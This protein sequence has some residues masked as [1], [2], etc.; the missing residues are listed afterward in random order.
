VPG[1]NGDVE[2]D[3]AGY[4]D[5]VAACPG[6]RTLRRLGNK[7]ASLIL[8]ELGKGPHRHGELSR[9][10]AGASKKMLTQTLR[11]LERDG[12]ITR[13]ASRGIPLEVNYQLTALGAGLLNV[14]EGV[15]DWAERHVEE[16]DN[17][18]ATFDLAN[19][20]VNAPQ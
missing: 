9:S 2:L 14:I 16:I 15:A 20:R 11:E 6:H 18:R 7:W 19:R 1:Q 8:K 17:A 5:A 12:L 13:T 3:R 4:L 10:I